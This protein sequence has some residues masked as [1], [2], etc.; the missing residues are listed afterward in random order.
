MGREVSAGKVYT[1]LTVRD[2]MAAGLA[3]VKSKLASVKSAISGVF[4]L[5]GLMTGA[6]LTGAWMGIRRIAQ[7]ADN[8]GKGSA[9]LG[10]ATDEYQRLAAMAKNA[11]ADVGSVESAFRFA[12][13]TAIDARDGVKSANDALA[14]VGLTAQTLAGLAPERQFELIATAIAAIP[15]PT[16]RSARATQ[17]LGRGAMEIMPL[18][19]NFRELR[20]E[21]EATQ[22]LMDADAIAAAEEFNDTLRQLGENIQA[23]LVNSGLMKWLERVGGEI[24][25]IVGGMDKVKERAGKDGDLKTVYS[26]GLTGYAEDVL[27]RATGGVR[28][29]GKRGMTQRSGEQ[30]RLGKK[31]TQQEYDA[32]RSRPDASLEDAKSKRQERLAQARQREEVKAAAARAAKEEAARKEVAKL[33]NLV[34]LMGDK[35]AAQRLINEGKEREAV[36]TQAVLDAQRAIGRELTAQ[37]QARVAGVAGELYDAA[38]AGDAAAAI[39]GLERQLEIQRMLNDGREREVAITRALED[40]R[41]AAG[42]ELADEE[43]ARVEEI[44]AALHDARAGVKDAATRLQVAG[45]FTADARMFGGGAAADRTAKAS[46]EVARNT[47]RTVQLLK[48]GGLAFS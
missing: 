23:A 47:K 21:V 32:A 46:E 42:R 16:E 19:M 43:R 18:I 2:R 12:A 10:I 27:H 48:G 7:A 28:A 8:I 24:Q 20:A 3:S 6:G 25:H 26:S 38:N 9:R 41:R 11:G 4:S 13:R 34:A 15:D 36:V 45:S 31:M 35:V 37:E 40:A 5:G 14:S 17:L 39:A 29:F 30:V 1:E 33:D 22:A 44:A